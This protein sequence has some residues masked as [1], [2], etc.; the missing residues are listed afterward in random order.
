[1]AYSKTTWVNE[2]PPALDATNL[3]KIE[4]GLYEAHSWLSSPIKV[5]VFTTPS[6]SYPSGNTWVYSSDWHADTIDG[7]TPIGVLQGTPNS[8]GAGLI[9]GIALN[10]S[11]N[12]DRFLGTVH[13]ATGSAIT[14]TIQVPVLYIRNELL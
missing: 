2:G 11:V 12:G 13:N 5:Q 7:Y 10:F 4:Q 14:G 9:C 8:G 1:M 3:N 6:K